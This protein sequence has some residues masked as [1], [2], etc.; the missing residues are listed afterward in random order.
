MTLEQ[1][2]RAILESNFTQTK[3]EL[4]DIAVKNICELISKP[5]EDIRTEL[6]K[7]YLEA[8]KNIPNTEGFY[9][10]GYVDGIGRALNILD[11]YDPSKS[12]K[13]NAFDI[14]EYTWTCPVCGFKMFKVVGG[15]PNCPKCG[16]KEKENI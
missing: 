6:D 13:Q 15:L 3:D 16:N 8:Y 10:G 7:A 1:N 5:F 11:D 2:V 12:E 4:I 9:G 14:E